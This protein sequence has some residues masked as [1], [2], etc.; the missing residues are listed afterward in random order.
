[1]FFGG[2]LGYMVGF[3]GAILEALGLIFLSKQWRL[4]IMHSFLFGKSGYQ[5]W[6]F[7]LGYQGAIF[8]LF[9]IFV[10]NRFLRPYKTV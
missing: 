9:V 10:F 1:M 5:S 6:V 7:K 8:K 3:L 2:Y 4:M